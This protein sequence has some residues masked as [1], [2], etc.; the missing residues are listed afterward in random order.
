LKVA[1]NSDINRY[2][3]P[4]DIETLPKRRGREASNFYPSLVEAFLSSS[5]AAMQVDVGKIGRKPETV[6]SGL[7]KAIKS[8]EAQD[9]VRVSMIGGDVILVRR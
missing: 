4:R 9:K 5:E 3:I 7:V 6:R 8:A 2:L 1:K